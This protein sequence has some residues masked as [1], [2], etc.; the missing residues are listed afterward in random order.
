MFLLKHLVLAVLTAV[1]SGQGSVSSDDSICTSELVAERV[2][3][4]DTEGPCDPL[5]IPSEV[6]YDATSCFQPPTGYCINEVRV[7]VYAVTAGSY[8]FLVLVGG[9]DLAIVDFPEGNFVE[10]DPATGQVTGS[11]V[12]AALDEIIADNAIQ[13]VGRVTM[14]YSHAH[15]DHIGAASITYDHIQQTYAPQ[16]GIKIVASEETDEYLQE[17]IASGFYSFRAP[18][19]T[20]VVKNAKTFSV[21]TSGVGLEYSLTVATGHSGKRDMVFFMEANLISGEPAVMMFVDVVFNGWAPFFSAG[22][23]T[24]LGEFK[25]VRPL[26]LCYF[27][28]P[29]TVTTGIHCI[30]THSLTLHKPHSHTKCF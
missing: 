12:T 13:Q 25:A 1:A 14:V 23:S 4:F 6:A 24:D 26:W 11:K 9:D 20:N 27:C 30:L 17:R 8:W 28:V 10:R 2:A 16:N 3:C 21:A 5:P 22:L 18:A 19:P 29:F 7:G 15:F